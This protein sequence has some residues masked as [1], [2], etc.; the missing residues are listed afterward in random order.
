M[1]WSIP[2]VWSV[3]RGL[4]RNLAMYCS[5]DDWREKGAGTN[6]NSGHGWGGSDKVQ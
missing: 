5:K 2:K 1:N 6:E 3:A 4:A